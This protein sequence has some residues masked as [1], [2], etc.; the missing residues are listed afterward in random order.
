MRTKP[1]PAAKEKRRSRTNK[2]LLP[3]SA[4]LEKGNQARLRTGGTKGE[5]EKKSLTN[6]TTSSRCR[7]RLPGTDNKALVLFL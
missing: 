6:G 4:F 1:S 2:T 3:P 5:K 7:W